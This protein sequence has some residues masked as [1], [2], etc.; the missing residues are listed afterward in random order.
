MKTYILALSQ[1]APPGLADWDTCNLHVA[2][3][4][5]LLLKNS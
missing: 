1:T 5:H 3:A 2:D 4:E